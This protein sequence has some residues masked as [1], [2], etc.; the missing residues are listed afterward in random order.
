M[1]M[2]CHFNSWSLGRSVNATV[3]LP[4][5]VGMHQNKSHKREGLFPVLYLLHGGGSDHTHWARH[6]SVER[7]AEAHRIAVVMPHS[8]DRCYRNAELRFQNDE[9]HVISEQNELFFLRELPEW[10][11]A[12]FPVSTAPEH[13]YIAGFSLGGYGAAYYGFTY[14]KHYRAVG[15]LS[16]YVYDP[17][18]FD[19]KLRNAMTKA[20]MAERFF[21]EL[22]SAIRGAEELPTVFISHGERE[23]TEP[24]FV[25]ADI[26]RAKGADVITDFGKYPYGHEWNA[27]DAGI[28]SFL[29]KIPRSDLFSRSNFQRSTL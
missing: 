20:E 25:L 7:Y 22:L 3:I 4:T 26:L 15:L 18:L 8:Q 12:N 13:S 28:L 1:I 24:D 27:W 2:R 9:G 6:T 17:A 14:P 19:P 23:V 29:N 11:G 21:P 10:M 5:D 16:A